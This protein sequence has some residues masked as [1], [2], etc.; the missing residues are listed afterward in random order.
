VELDEVM[1]KTEGKPEWMA[2]MEVYFQNMQHANGAKNQA[3]IIGMGY[4]PG[5]DTG[6]CNFCGEIRHYMA[7]CEVVVQ[8]TRNRKIKKNADGR[9]VLS[10]GAY[11]S[12]MIPGIWLKDRIDKWHKCNPGIII[13]TGLA[14]VGNFM[15]K[16]VQPMS[17]INTDE[18]ISEELLTL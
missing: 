7:E 9:I 11:V 12:R 17:T 2:E 16:C 14:A 10:T 4:G 15:Y 8:Y 5:R 18:I 13:A 3:L 1:P 6:A